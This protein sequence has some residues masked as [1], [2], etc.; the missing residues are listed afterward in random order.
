M[1]VGYDNGD[2]YKKGNNMKRENKFFIIGFIILFVVV[3]FLII[4]KNNN[5]N[6]QSE[7]MTT[8]QI[9]TKLKESDTP[10]SVEKI[11]DTQ[12]EQN[13]TLE[14]SGNNKKAKNG[15]LE[16]AEED[17]EQE[18]DV[19]DAF[20]S[21]TQ[22]KNSNNRKKVID[23]NTESPKENVEKSS[24]GKEENKEEGWGNFY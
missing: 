13:S 5:Q 19:H 10:G 21:K 4:N 17:S 6:H 20:D 9:E 12:I 8:I 16:I 14:T 18:I 7:E 1:D 24:D 22:Q 3:V 2:M 23:K 15:L 11:K